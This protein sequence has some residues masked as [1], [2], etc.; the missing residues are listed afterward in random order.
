MRRRFEPIPDPAG[1]LVPPR[2]PPRTAVAAEMLP[3]PEWRPR[4]R[5]TRSRT[6][7]RAAAAALLQGVASAAGSF[8]RAA[9]RLA[10]R[11]AT[12]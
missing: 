9:Y 2:R 3:P 12:H 1:A 10:E 7:L 6:R 5:A 4:L 8:E 11:I